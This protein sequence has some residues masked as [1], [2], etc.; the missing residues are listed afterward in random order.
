MMI[1]A[2]CCIHVLLYSTM[3]CQS[4]LIVRGDDGRFLLVETTSRK[5]QLGGCMLRK[6]EDFQAAAVRCL[7]EVSP[8][9]SLISSDTLHRYTNFVWHCDVQYIIYTQIPH[10]YCVSMVK[11]WV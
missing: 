5:L 9:A 3:D 10:R 8:S 4:L 6:G 1:E 11:Y 2:G 7:T